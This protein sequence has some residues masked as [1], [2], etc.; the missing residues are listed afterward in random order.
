M[1]IPLAARLRE[2]TRELH[3]EVER[4]GVMRSL[5]RGELGRAGYCA[6]LRN[7]HALYLPLEQALARHA[8]HPGLAA[9]VEPALFR[10][11]ALAQDLAGLHG[12][13]WADEIAVVPA[14]RDYAAHLR[15][16]D[17]S[18]PLRLA[19]HAYV[20][21]LGD[22]SGGQ[23][24]ASRVARQLALDEGTGVAFYDFG[25]AAVVTARAAALRLALDQLARDE[26]EAAA[27]VDE[28]CAA[29]VRHRQLFE[30]LSLPTAHTGP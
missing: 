26:D 28:A 6:L 22:L 14:A 7:L 24:L 2:A 5:L 12:P 9:L 15:E 17:A 30:A 13:R 3:T 1:S 27:L 18:A 11:E 8:A 4:A 21:Y 20:R 29:F 25:P 23:L 19:A 16:L 10:S